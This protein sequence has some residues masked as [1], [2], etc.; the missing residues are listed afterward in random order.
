MGNAKKFEKDLTQGNIFTQL[1]LFAIPLFI[2]NL[3]QSAYSVADMIILGNFSNAG[4]ISGVNSAG[5]VMVILTNLAA[6]ISTGGTVMIGQYLGSKKTNEINKAISTLLITLAGMAVVFAA[7]SF[8]LINVILNALNLEGSAYN[9]AKVYLAISLLGMLFIFGYNA[10]SSIMRGLGDNKTPLIFVGV[11]GVINIILDLIFVAY[12][13]MGAGGA[14][15]ATIIAQGVSMV[16]CII[17]LKVNNF[18]FDFKPSS[19]KWSAN[20]FR[21]LM[22]VGLPMGIQHVCTN[23][24]FLILTA[25]INATGGI[26]AG[27]ASGVVMKFNSFALLPNIAISSSVAAMI[28]QNIGA[29]KIDRVKKSVYYGLA[30]CLSICAVVFVI[31]NVFA[32]NIFAIFGCEEE[33]VDIGIRY[34]H[35]FSFEYATM[36]FIVSYSGAFIGTGYGWISMICDV[37][38]AFLIRIPVAYLIGIVLGY[39]V[40]G[41]VSAIPIATAIVSSIAAGFYYFY[42]KPRMEKGTL[43]QKVG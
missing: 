4:S 23:L 38:P 42:L 24:S 8:A 6:G 1:I 21:T 33:V 31:A 5:Q 32:P 19:F 30:I 15:A 3:F 29:N 39:G 17:Y 11:A 43:K 7:A 35:A 20:M 26:A 2:S 13:K 9:E 40:I 34:M 37:V 16:S 10:L 18:R 36:A 22:R 27:A 25:L 14:A 28:S 41:I 12:F